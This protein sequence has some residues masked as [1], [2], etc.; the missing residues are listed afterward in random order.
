MLKWTKGNERMDKRTKKEEN[1][2]RNKY[3]D[4]WMNKKRTNEHNKCEPNASQMQTII[5]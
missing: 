5:F 2:G 4:K 3:M 1:K